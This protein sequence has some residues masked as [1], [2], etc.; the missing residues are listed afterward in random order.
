MGFMDFFK[1]KEELVSPMRAE[2]EKTLLALIDCYQ[3]FYGENKD[4]KLSF[5]GL[6]EYGTR[7][8]EAIYTRLY[9]ETT[10]TP[11]PFNEACVWEE[12]PEGQKNELWQKAQCGTIA[13]AS[14]GCGIY[15]LLIV[16]GSCAGQVWL[17]TES[18]VTPV[19]PNLTLSAWRDKCLESGNSFWREVVARWG[20][21]E[22]DFFYGHV[23]PKMIDREQFAFAVSSPLCCVCHNMMLNYAKQNDQE[24]VITDPA[25]T[26]VFM[27]NLM[28]ERVP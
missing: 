7:G 20:D 3:K 12:M 2:D 22:N 13:I 10:R 18:G 21:E 4:E 19:A 17:Y 24:I 27:T 16:N 6:M 28:V 1:K 14:E 25:G 5:Y 15:W 11:F 9:S 8:P 26:K 23:S